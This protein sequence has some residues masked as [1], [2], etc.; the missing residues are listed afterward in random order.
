MAAIVFDVASLYGRVFGEGRGVRFPDTPQTPKGDEAGQF[1]IVGAESEEG[2]EFVSVRQSINA[3]SYYGKPL[4]MP[5]RLGGL[6]LPNEPTI[7]ITGTK[8]ITETPL[9]GSTRRGTV[10]ELISIGDYNI[11]IRGVAINDGQK[12]IYPEDSV[13]ALN[14]LFLRGESLAIECAMTN[15][16]G[17]YRLVIKEV[18]FPE[19]IG[20]QHAQAY[21]FLC[22]SDEDFD[23]EID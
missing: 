6:I 9:A 19:M 20:V 17:I 10:K 13:K 21:E 4:F 1:D 16:F 22:V 5:V 11:T 8:L 3:S 18:D 23:L 14:D 7:R 15:L 2:T 12:N